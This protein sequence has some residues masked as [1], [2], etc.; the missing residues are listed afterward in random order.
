[1]R[2][3]DC[4]LVKF[5]RHV[6]ERMFERG[7]SEIAVKEIVRDGEVIEEYPE[8][9]PYPSRLLLGWVGGR[10]LHV[11]VGYDAPSG[12]CVVITAYVPDAAQWGKDFKMRRRG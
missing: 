2:G 10:P 6:L 5:S 1:M 7:I 9:T 11:V 8:D 3:I 12:L 4:R